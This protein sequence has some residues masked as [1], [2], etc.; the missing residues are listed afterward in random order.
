MSPRCFEVHSQIV[1]VF[2]L[3]INRWQLY[4]FFGP[5]LTKEWTL[6][7]DMHQSSKTKVTVKQQGLAAI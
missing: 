3:V 5:S 6:L 2:H 7:V 4:A 1:L